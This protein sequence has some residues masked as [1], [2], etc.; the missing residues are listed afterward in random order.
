MQ[1]KRLSRPVAMKP[2]NQEQSFDKLVPSRLQLPLYL[3]SYHSGDTKDG[4]CWDQE[5]KKKI[6]KKNL[7]RQH[8]GK[9]TN[10]INGQPNQQFEGH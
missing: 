8:D 5:Q 2:D 7:V 4:R 3:I 6:N 9:K 10:L 1:F